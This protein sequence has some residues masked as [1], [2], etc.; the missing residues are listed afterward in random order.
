LPWADG[1]FEVLK[2]LRWQVHAYGSADADELQKLL[3]LPV[4]VFP[5]APQT[6]LRD[7]RLYLVRPDGFVAAAATP[8]DA[9]EV[10]RR[11]ASC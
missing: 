3:D 11:A 9:P 8:Q 5:P 4:H 7:D 6:A 1:N 2:D 10:F